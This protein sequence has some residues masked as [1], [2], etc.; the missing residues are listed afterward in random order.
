MK[1]ENY[2]CNELINEFYH[3]TLI[4]IDAE[5]EKTLE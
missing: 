4:D 3:K 1:N 5:Y 2:I